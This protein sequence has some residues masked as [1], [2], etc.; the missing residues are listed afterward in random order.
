MKLTYEYTEDVNITEWRKHSDNDTLPQLV[1]D[2]G[3]AAIGAAKR[4]G[5]NNP[6]KDVYMEVVPNFDEDRTHETVKVVIEYADDKSD[7]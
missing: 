6:I 1:E 7:L 4:D 2:C 3:W 5:Y